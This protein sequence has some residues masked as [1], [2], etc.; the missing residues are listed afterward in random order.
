MLR[1]DVMDFGKI[2]NLTRC[3][4]ARFRQRSI[5]RFAK[6]MRR[7]DDDLIRIVLPRWGHPRMSGLA[8]GL[9]AAATTQ[10]SRFGWTLLQAVRRRRAIGV[11]A[12]CRKL[13]FQLRYG[14]TEFFNRFLLFCDNRPQLLDDDT[15]LGDNSLQRKNKRV[16]LVIA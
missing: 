5:A 9:L 13:G 6:R 10:G 15:L 7:M 8:A 16:F 1:H 2:E 4:K 14:R 11:R 3:E 12:V